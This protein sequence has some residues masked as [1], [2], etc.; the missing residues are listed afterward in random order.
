MKNF[1][2]TV[3]QSSENSTPFFTWDLLA[4]GDVEKWPPGLVEVARHGRHREVGVRLYFLDG[5]VEA[6]FPDRRAACL[7][8]MQGNGLVAQL[9]G[10]G[11][12]EAAGG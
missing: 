10:Q 7:G 5:S 2:L 11:L 1:K 6:E 8:H 4:E 9:A 3:R 12:L